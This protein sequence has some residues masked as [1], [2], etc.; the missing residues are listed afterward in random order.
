M[1]WF[2]DENN[3]PPEWTQAYEYWES[4]DFYRAE[5]FG[6]IRRAAELARAWDRV[7]EVSPLYHIKASSVR[8]AIR[9]AI[10]SEK[11]A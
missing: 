10:G 5:A 9:V 2:N 3:R 4:L 11:E 1:T 6:A 8:I 7:E